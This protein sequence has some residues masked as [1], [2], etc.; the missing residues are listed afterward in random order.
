V[1]QAGCGRLAGYVGCAGLASWMRAAVVQSGGS[2]AARCGSGAPPPPWW[3]CAPLVAQGVTQRWS[4]G[5]PTVELSRRRGAP[6][7]SR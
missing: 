5:H 1:H 4:R 6:R 7:A 2:W 3:G